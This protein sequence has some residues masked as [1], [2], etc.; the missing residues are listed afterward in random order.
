MVAKQWKFQQFCK[1]DIFKP[2]F[3]LTAQVYMTYAYGA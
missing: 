2:D 3:L 1:N